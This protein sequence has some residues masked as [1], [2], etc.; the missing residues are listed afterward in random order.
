MSNY[1]DLLGGLRVGTQIHLDKKAVCLNENTL[2][3][4]GP[5]NNLAFTYPAGLVVYCYTERTRW[6]WREIVLENETDIYLLAQPFTY[7]NGHTIDGF[8]YSNKSFNFHKM[9][10]EQGQNGAPG[11]PGTPG[12]DGNDGREIELGSNGTHIQWRYVGEPT[13]IN[14]ISVETL[15]GQQGPPGPPGAYPP[16]L[17]KNITNGDTYILTNADKNYILRI[18][19]GLSIT[20]IVIPADLEEDFQAFF[21]QGSTNANVVFQA[22]GVVLSSPAGNTLNKIKGAHYWAYLVQFEPNF[23]HLT[24]ALKA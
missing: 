24:G 23:Y 19:E 5:A 18:D 12:Q 1:N 21:L 20:T 8:D 22:S 13:W 4:L 6:E 15:Q 10:L 7:P 3:N 2:A 14:L 11:A 17:R 9:S 16:L